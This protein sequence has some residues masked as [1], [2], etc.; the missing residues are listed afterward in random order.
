[1]GVTISGLSEL[2]AALHQLPSELLTEAS[3]IVQHTAEQAMSEMAAAYPPTTDL[4][5]KLSLS[6][7]SDAG[8]VA[9]RVVN[10]HKLAAMYEYGTMVRHTALG[11]NRGA[12]P[13]RP[14]V[15]PIA[16]RNRRDV[17]YPALIALVEQTGA[18]VVGSLP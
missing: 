15:V 11:Y 10:R 6:G 18:T 2:I 12:M 9:Y 1:M 7:S 8:G 4:A 16:I 13:A 5:S 14:T 3:A 17:M